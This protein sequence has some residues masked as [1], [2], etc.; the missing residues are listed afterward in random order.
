VADLPV[1]VVLGLPDQEPPLDDPQS[2]AS[3]PTFSCFLV[4]EDGMANPVVWARKLKVV[5]CSH[6]T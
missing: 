3:K 2:N 5:P 1:V 6:S 4:N